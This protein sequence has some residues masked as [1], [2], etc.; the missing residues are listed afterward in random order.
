VASA[1]LL[2]GKSHH[3][4]LWRRQR[5]VAVYGARL[6]PMGRHRPCMLNR[7]KTRTGKRIG[8]VV[9]ATRRVSNAVTAGPRVVRRPRTLTHRNPPDLPGESI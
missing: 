8:N 3:V 2:T 9:M 5:V 7:S 4:F 1:P 6:Q